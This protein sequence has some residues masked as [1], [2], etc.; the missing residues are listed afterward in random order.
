M[1]R[2][3]SE[4]DAFAPKPSAPHSKT[5]PRQALHAAARYSW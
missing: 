5:L 4:L 2:A 1:A 3:T